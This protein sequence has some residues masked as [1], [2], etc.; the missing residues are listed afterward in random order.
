MTAR[1]G[2]GGRR[3]IG[4]LA[5]G[6]AAVA[7]RVTG[8]GPPAIFTTLARARRTYWGWLGFAAGLM[9][10]GRLPRRESEM[11]IL[12]VAHLRGSE[13]EWTHHRELGR[14]AGLST[15]QIEDLSRPVP[16]GWTPRETAM[17]NAVDELVADRDLG[18]E[19]FA[20]LRE[21]LDEAE[22]VELLLLTGH[23]DMLATTLGVLR[24]PP[25]APRGAA[26]STGD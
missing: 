4:L 5:T 17:L 1:I 8:T 22:V 21:H 16:A 7:G 11:V 25:D 13:Y 10:F 18:E 14:R 2:P 15:A 20:A 12:R 19:P 3:E 6:F 9:P 23:Y 26:P 24:V